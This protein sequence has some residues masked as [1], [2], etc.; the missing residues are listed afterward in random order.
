VAGK[1]ISLSLLRISLPYLRDAPLKSEYFDGNQDV[2]ACSISV[3]SGVV[4]LR[5][6]DCRPHAQKLLGGFQSLTTHAEM[7]RRYQNRAPTES[8]ARWQFL[9]GRTAIRAGVEIIATHF[10]AVGHASID[11]LTTFLR[12][13]SSKN[14]DVPSLAGT[15]SS[16]GGFYEKKCREK[17]FVPGKTIAARRALASAMTSGARGER[18]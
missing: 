6:T 9:V 15:P 18:A 12:G 14:T 17:S 13:T 4:F 5:F 8:A 10:Q 3:I 2:G 1:G 16:M 7:T 11:G